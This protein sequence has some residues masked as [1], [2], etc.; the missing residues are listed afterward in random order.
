[1]KRLW[2]DRTPESG[3]AREHRA[4]FTLIEMMMALALFGILAA[5]A[6]PSI[7]RPAASTKGA[8]LALSA[9]LSEARQQAITQQ[10][11]VALIIPSGN[12]LQGQANSYYI[13]A[14]EQP[15][16]TQV[17]RLG[18]EPSGLRLM[19]G[20][21]PL[22]AGKLRV[23]ALTTTIT[24]PPEATSESDFD[25][26]LWGLPATKDYAFIF[27]PRGTLL[28]NDLP[29]FD[30][31]YHIVVSHGGLST[32][33]AA[34]G[35]GVMA[36]P[37]TTHRL[38]HIGSPYT[39]SIEPTGAVSV[40]P[41]LLA[42]SDSGVEI[43]EQAA[44]IVPPEPPDLSAPASSDPVVN[45][46]TLLPDP[47]RQDLPT[48]VDILLAPGGHMTM[49]VRAQSPERVP[50]FCRWKVSG[51]GLSA[52]EEV[53]AT[54]LPQTQEWE[55][56]WQWRLPTDA[57]KDDQFTLQG[58]VKD[59]YGNET[60][61]GLGAADPFVVQTGD[62]SLRVVF[63]T[64]REGNH[65]VFT[66]YGD[67]TGQRNLTSS[68]TSTGNDYGQVWSP[69]GERIMFQS[70]RDGSWEIYVMNADGTGQTNLTNDPADEGGQQFG[71]SWSPDGGRIA[72]RSNKNGNDDIWVMNAD[73]SGQIALTDHPFTDTAPQW[74]PDGNR[75]A[76]ISDRGGDF[77]VY[78][79][80]VD[81]SG[82]PVNLS[83]DP[84]EE[85]GPFWSPDSSQILFRSSRSGDY[86]T[87]LVS[88][89]G[90]GTPQKVADSGG[91][92]V[93][94]PDGSRFVITGYSYSEGRNDV[95]VVSSD[96]LTETC[97]TTAL[98]SG[99]GSPVWTPDGN[100]IVFGDDD[101]Y[102]MNADGSDIRNLSQAPGLTNQSP[103]A[104]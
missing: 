62:S 10:V 97:L 1:M 101:I 31:A 48:G 11:P 59:A 16:V 35:T 17:K 95:Y 15:R 18:D 43:S 56:V 88:A 96:G 24:P 71:Q 49:T 76:F 84:A 61:I 32:A 2:P 65:D 4:G 63:D 81:G 67:G 57:R 68:D 85:N 40:T 54:Y 27:S 39:V 99:A 8:A 104:R 29:H 70:D 6:G 45:S 86:C 26:N 28:T 91:I 3:R 87:Y 98:A 83:N 20:H 22:D 79:M 94:S 75:I 90:S 55:S 5:T 23:P 53:R 7:R 77:D 33:A 47:A 19:V 38:T 46:L 82:T 66:M 51:G 74:S 30:G 37:P 25:V 34:P 9:A 13:A 92:P 69:D 14:G 44:S 58:V 102:I 12:G 80:N 72:Y 60:S 100:R 64:Y 41:G 21:W 78:V 103:K 36:T 73:G 52:P 50:L 42:A 89:D 93:W